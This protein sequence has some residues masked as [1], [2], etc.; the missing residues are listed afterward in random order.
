[1]DSKP[2]AKGVI[3]F[4]LLAFG[5]AWISWEIPIRLGVLPHNPL[6]QVAALPGGFAPAIA[7]IIVRRW[8]THEGF[9]DAG[10]RPHLRKWP[11]Y[12][13]GWLLPLVMTA[14]IVILAVALGLSQPDFTLKQ[15]LAVLA[16]GN[17]G[18]LPAIPGY[19]WAVLPIQLLITA[20]VATPIL[21]GE[22][23][24]W[25]GYLQLRLLAQRPLLAAIATGVIWGM[26]HL[27]LNIRGYNFPDHPLLGLL[28]FPVSTTLISI[29]FGWLRL[30]TGSIWA[31]SL[32]HA[33]TNAVGGSLTMLL[34]AGRPGGIF[35]SYLGILSW[36]PLGALCA[37]IVL[38]GQLRQ[39]STSGETQTGAE[40][41]S[42]P[43]PNPA[44][45]PGESPAR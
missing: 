25:R 4:L 27:P 36:I 30:R 37:W 16:P 26:W 2:T 42:S 39:E 3:S 11:Y 15:A 31:S 5:L 6:F 41:G 20:L 18:S 24:G 17:A 35:V 44:L 10:L 9:A 21:W 32:A 33:A 22:E 38:T 40:A 29:I 8:I 43:S 28:V 19:V 7:A 45:A 13:V 1:M 12:L 34:F 14:C 23:F